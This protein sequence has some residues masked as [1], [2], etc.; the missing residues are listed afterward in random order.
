MLWEGNFYSLKWVAFIL[1]S[2]SE[3]ADRTITWRNAQLNTALSRYLETRL[4][5]E[6]ARRSLVRLRFL[7]ESGNEIW[8]EVWGLSS[9]TADVSVCWVVGLGSGTFFRNVDVSS[10]D[11]EGKNQ[12]HAN[13]QLDVAG[14]T[15]NEGINGAWG[16]GLVSSGLGWGH[17]GGCTSGLP[18]FSKYLGITSKF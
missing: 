3:F 4:A 18:L 1:L 16:C 9:R 15:W 17:T 5:V 14:N 7:L 13:L 12:E 11:N 6:R 2:F 10:P 8:C